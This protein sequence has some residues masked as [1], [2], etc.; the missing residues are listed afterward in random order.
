MHRALIRSLGLTGSATPAARVPALV[1]AVV[2]TMSL[3]CSLS[4]TACHSEPVAGDVAPAPPASGAAVVPFDAARFDASAKGFVD[5]ALT[6]AETCNLEAEQ[7]GYW[8]DFITYDVCSTDAKDIAGVISASD[9]FQAAATGMTDLPVAATAVVEQVKIFRSWVEQV[10]KIKVTRGTMLVYQGLSLAYNAYKPNA[11]VPT[12]PKHA[13][14]QYFVVYPSR[15]VAYIWEQRLCYDPET[16]YYTG[17]DPT[18]TTVRMDRYEIH[19]KRGT[20]LKWKTSP[21]GPFLVD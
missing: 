10:Q 14:D 18:K 3:A 16:L 17:C 12:E 6:Y 9:T 15:G 11:V 1:W 5:A 8:F 7:P 2:A 19:R 20:P 13:L 21:Q 4:L